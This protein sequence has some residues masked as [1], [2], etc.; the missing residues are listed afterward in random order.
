MASFRK[1]DIVLVR[2]PRLIGRLIRFFTR[3]W[4]SHVAVYAGNGLVFE[5]RPGGAGLTPLHTYNR[6]GYAIRVM[7]LK[8]TS[9]RSA[10]FSEHAQRYV[11]REYD[12]VQ[13]IWMAI[14]FLF[15]VQRRFNPPDRRKRLICSELVFQALLDAQ[16]PTPDVKICNSTPK[17]FERWNFVERIY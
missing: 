3:G 16:L 11:G 4:A 9:A 2:S 17:D 12:F 14:V 5:G 6:P 7:R 13:L 1:G 15:R 10:R 8:T